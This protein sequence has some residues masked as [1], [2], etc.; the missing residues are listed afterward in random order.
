MGGKEM[1]TICGLIDVV[2]GE[3]KVKSES[4]YE[5]DANLRDEI[6]DKVKQLCGRFPMRY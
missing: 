3:I 5:I 1:D 4:D 6:R 2:L